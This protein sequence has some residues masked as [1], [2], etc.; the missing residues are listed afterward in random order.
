MLVDGVDVNFSACGIRQIAKVAV[1]LNKELVNTGA[2]RLNTVMGIVLE[3]VKFNVEDYSGHVI[4]INAE[5]VDQRM[6]LLKSMN[7]TEDLR[8]FIL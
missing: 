3:D 2:R 7:K 6:G 5:Y 8:K 4:E 1:E